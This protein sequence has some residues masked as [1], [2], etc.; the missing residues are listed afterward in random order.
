MRARIRAEK[1]R[2]RHC[3]GILNYLKKLVNFMKKIFLLI[4]IIFLLTSCGSAEETGKTPE[5]AADTEE[6][7]S[8]GESFTQAKEE[9][10]PPEL[11]E[12]DFEG[13]TFIFLTHRHEHVD[14]VT[15]DPRE[16]AA[17]AE[18][19]EPINDAV[20]RRNVVI[21]GQYNIKIGMFPAAD[22]PSALNKA[23]KAGED[24][25]DAVIMFNNNVPN[26]VPKGNLLETKNL[27]YIDFS[28]PWWDSAAN[29]LSIDNK[30]Y[31]M[32]GDLL[33]LDN[34][35]TNALLFNKN[36]LA[37][38][39]LETPYAIVKAGEWTFD[40]FNE[41]TKAVSKDLN[42]D[43]VMDY[44]DQWGF[45]TYNDTLH[46]LLVS[47]GGALALKNDRDIPYM[48]FAEERN[49]SITAKAMDVMYDTS[50]VYN[51]SILGNTNPNA[52]QVGYDS[53]ESGRVLFYWVR[54]RVVEAMRNM[55][56]DFGIIP[57]PKY[58]KSQNNYYSVVNPY[59]GVMLGVPIT[60]KDPERTSV[61]LEALS[62]ES[63]YTL[64][65]AYYEVTLT[66]KF[67]R[68]EESEEMLDV[69]FGSRT[70]DIGAVYSF[71]N[72]FLDFINLASTENRNVASYYEKQET[73]MQS[74][75]D[76]LVETF[77]GLE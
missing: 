30:G 43:G 56:D 18:T 2:S 9:K 26:I 21:E 37:D 8:S 73:K 42:G 77:R 27:P 49:L 61:I 28:K 38:N 74:A 67:A 58:E 47:G 11:P 44:T 41:M 54:M 63:R 76:K 57:L 72:V 39:G 65:P 48:S 62:A 24:A 75:I 12:K 70:Y 5:N 55:E 19:G 50:S 52:G 69:I 33:I 34:E 64:Q 15:P 40:K 59:T 45:F 60:A 32:A 29:A 4:L 46:A 1:R 51:I 71:G 7:F 14:W 35:A 36:L 22:E 10:I 25:Y 31:L 23:V 6:G 53:F 3:A 66:R 13:H 17:E 16:I 68:D 20:Y